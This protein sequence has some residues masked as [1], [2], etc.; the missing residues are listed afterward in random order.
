M[1]SHPQDGPRHPARGYKKKI[2]EL[3]AECERLREEVS[4]SDAVCR[5]LG[6][7]VKDLYPKLPAGCQLV[8]LDEGR[9][10]GV[11]K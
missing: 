7:F 3:E 4:K 11:L 10:A 9:K 1:K 5:K 8:F 6:Q 2:A